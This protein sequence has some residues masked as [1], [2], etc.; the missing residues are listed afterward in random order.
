LKK[1]DLLKI[2]YDLALV[3]VYESEKMYEGLY[4][5][6]KALVSDPIKEQKPKKLCRFR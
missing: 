3:I 6:A 2:K 1:W 4:K 5:E